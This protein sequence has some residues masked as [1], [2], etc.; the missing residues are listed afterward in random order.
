MCLSVSAASSFKGKVVS[1]ADGD[2]LTVVTSDKKM[3]K[4]RLQG[5]DAPENSQP[6]GKKAQKALSDKV[7]D[8]EVTVNWSEYLDETT[9][10]T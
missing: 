3:F 1:V 5:I 4:I 7:L 2:T 6:A 10:E 8:K 9:Y